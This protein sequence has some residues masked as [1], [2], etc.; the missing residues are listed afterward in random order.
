MPRRGVISSVTARKLLVGHINRQERK[1]FLSHFS[2][3]SQGKKKS[4]KVVACWN[5]TAVWQKGRQYKLQ[6]SAL[7]SKIR[8]FLR[9][10]W[11]N[12]NLTDQRFCNHGL[13]NYCSDFHNSTLHV[14]LLPIKQ[15]RMKL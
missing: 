4:C 3:K 15:T 1:T 11:M 7:C 6:E 13:C 12:F 8:F 9:K 5:I 2:Y 14:I 10:Q